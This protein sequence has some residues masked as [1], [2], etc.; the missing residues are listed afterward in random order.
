MSLRDCNKKKWR[1][2]FGKVFVALL[3]LLHGWNFWKSKVRSG[4]SLLINTSLQMEPCT[5][6]NKNKQ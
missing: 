1:F 6:K 5:S 3:L 2:A 4:E